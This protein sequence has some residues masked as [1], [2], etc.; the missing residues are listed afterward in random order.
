MQ[1]A[2]SSLRFIT[3]I[4]RRGAS[5]FELFI[6]ILAVIT[7]TW[8]RII[9]FYLFRDKHDWKCWGGRLS[10]WL[11]LPNPLLELSL[12]YSSHATLTNS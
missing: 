4:P 9:N 3:I 2:N 8:V 6:S 7:E 1:S 10:D 11:Y 12:L 5:D